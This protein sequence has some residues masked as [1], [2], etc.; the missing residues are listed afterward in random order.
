MHPIVSEMHARAV[1]QERHREAAAWRRA[2]GTRRSTPGRVTDRVRRRVRRWAA[3]VADL[4][5]RRTARP[6]PTHAVGAA[7]DAECCV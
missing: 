6:S 5:P 1:M 4:L 2:R 7:T 3:A